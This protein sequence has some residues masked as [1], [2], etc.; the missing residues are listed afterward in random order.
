MN[1][2]GKQ[3]M[4]SIINS[5]RSRHSDSRANLQGSSGLRL[6]AVRPILSLLACL[7]LVASLVP[8]STRAQEGLKDLLYTVGT[9]TTDG[10]G[11]DWAYVTWN[12][13]S[14]DQLAGWRFAVYAKAGDAASAATFSKRGT[15]QQVS[16]AASITP[17]LARAVNLG[18]N[19]ESLSNTLRGLFPGLS[20]FPAYTP[21]QQL[22]YAIQQSVS[23]PTNRNSLQIASRVH[24]AVSLALGLAW[25][26]PIAANQAMTFE[27]RAIDPISAAEQP[28]VGRV[29]L[30]GHQPVILPAPDRPLEVI[31]TSAKGDLNIRLRWGESVELRRLALLSYGYNVWRLP[32]AVAISRGWVD[33]PPTV[34][35]LAAE[36]TAR[37]VNNAPSFKR[38]DFV[39]GA[40][41]NSAADLASDPS[42][43]FFVDDNGRGTLGARPFNDGDEFCYFIAARDLLGREGLLSKGGFGIACRRLPPLAPTGLWVENDFD[44]AR[45][46]AQ[47]LRVSWTQNKWEID[48]SKVPDVVTHYAIYRWTNHAQIHTNEYFPLQRLLKIVPHDPAGTVNTVLDEGADGPKVSANGDQTFWYTVRAV[49]SNQ[50]G[51]VF[52]GNSAPAFGVIRLRAG[53]DGPEGQV[54]GS[55]GLPAVVA[56]NSSRVILESSADRTRVRFKLNCVRRDESVLWAQI[57]ISNSMVGLVRFARRGFAPGEALISL[58]YDHAIGNQQPLTVISCQVGDFNGRV[59]SIAIANGFGDS[60]PREFSWQTDFYAGSIFSTHLDSND[61]LLKPYLFFGAIS[62]SSVDYLANQQVRL[63]FNVDPFPLFLIQ[64]LD[65]GSSVWKDIG[66]S[67]LESG[68]CLVIHDSSCHE[69]EQAQWRALPLRLPDDGDCDHVA[70]VGNDPNCVSVSLEVRPGTREWRIYR[71]LD[72]GP[73]MLI[74]QGVTA[75]NPSKAVNRVTLCDDAM[76]PVTSSACYFGQ[77]LDANGNASPFRSLG[78]VKRLLAPPPT[79]MLASPENS[80]SVGNPQVVLRW[81]CP[82]AGVDRFR[83]NIVEK[84]HPAPPPQEKGVIQSAQLKK[85]ISYTPVLRDILSSSAKLSLF[86]PEVF[87]TGRVGADFQPGPNFNLTAKVRA[88]VTY[89]IFIEALNGYPTP[90]ASLVYE[91]TWQTPP[92]PQKV[93]WPARGLPPLSLFDDVSS[94]PAPVSDPRVRAVRI[95]DF[96]GGVDRRYPVGVVIGELHGIFDLPRLS[97]VLYNVRTADAAGYNFPGSALGINPDPNS[98]VFPR[99]SA[100]PTL[101]GERLLPIALYRQQVTNYYY[102]RVSGNVTQVTPM[103]EEIAWQ[104][105]PNADGRYRVSIPDRLICIA[106]FVS[107]FCGGDL[108]AEAGRYLILRDPQPILVGATYRYFV[109]RFKANREVD[110]V[111]PAGE[112]DIPYDL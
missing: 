75:Y 29:T 61:P 45:A 14:S 95:G 8:I 104:A 46:E 48:P 62:P 36:G 56:T 76:P 38:K 92:E 93:P 25:A 78:R 88:G 96:N 87:E 101:N 16:D 70:R 79:P 97:E 64:K 12:T 60:S 15:A 39:P 107:F 94:N 84:D 3:S 77:L 74:A 13:G 90:G 30:V 41:V 102:P 68:G 43:F 73:K 7:G 5:F 34:G 18:E 9:V 35:T 66:A 81:F 22:A 65:K 37:R 40:G 58:D 28:V 11:G 80:G 1:R 98:L 71:C 108:C 83:I 111:I 6:Q 24:P 55:C 51:L 33:A 63:C 100:N 31:E 2:W 103:I 47:R 69:L 109:V 50:C 82:P 57:S 10:P 105:N 19:T 21:A 32:K 42:T 85:V 20:A 99:V 110:Q 26:E 106:P 67:R 44:P 53:L 86:I 59:S 17:L 72:D 89:Q 54:T 49:K 91:F 27:I 52:S 4:N 23:N 112:I